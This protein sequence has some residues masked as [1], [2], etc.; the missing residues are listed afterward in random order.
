MQQC[1][2]RTGMDPRWGLGPQS[3][4]PAL[5]P[6]VTPELRGLGS[7]AQFCLL[8]GHAIG[9]LG[10]PIPFWPVPIQDLYRVRPPDHDS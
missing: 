7:E 9:E 3:T 4:W 6:D 8:S 1:L 5:G 2:G 10:P